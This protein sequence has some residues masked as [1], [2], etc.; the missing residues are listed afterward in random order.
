M[1]DKVMLSQPSKYDLSYLRS[2]RL[3]IILALYSFNPSYNKDT[4]STPIHEPISTEIVNNINN[5]MSVQT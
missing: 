4:N 2:V 1:V 3:C 5:N